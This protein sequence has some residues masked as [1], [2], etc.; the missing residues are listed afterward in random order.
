MSVVDVQHTK[1]SVSTNRQTSKPIPTP[2]NWINGVFGV[3][4][5]D[6]FV[7]RPAVTHF[8]NFPD[9]FSASP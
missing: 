3:K 4:Y 6:A 5:G 2:R 8:Q 7:N 1:S 9:T